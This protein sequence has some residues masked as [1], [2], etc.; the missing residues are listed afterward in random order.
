MESTSGVRR[1]AGLALL[2]M[3]RYF[4]EQGVAAQAFLEAGDTDTV[5]LLA[6]EAVVCQLPDGRAAVMGN[7]TAVTDPAAAGE[8]LLVAAE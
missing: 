4:W 2:A 5:I 3:Q 6:R 8:S 7:L 1:R